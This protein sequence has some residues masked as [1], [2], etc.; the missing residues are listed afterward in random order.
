MM[1][2]TKPTKQQARVL[3]F[4]GR[5]LSDKEIAREMGISASTV[6]AHLYRARKLPGLKSRLEI[7]KTHG[8]MESQELIFQ[9]AQAVV[10]ALWAKFHEQ[11]LRELQS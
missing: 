10:H 1:N 2:K 11:K 4:V 5:G 7:V 6:S 9:A 8:A 3:F